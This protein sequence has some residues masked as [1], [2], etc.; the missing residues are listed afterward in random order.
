MNKVLPAANIAKV[1]YYF[2]EESKAIGVSKLTVVANTQTEV[3]AN[4]TVLPYNTSGIYNHI[5]GPNDT[6]KIN[7]NKITTYF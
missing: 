2:N 5:T 7:V 1:P 6:P 4:D 3:A